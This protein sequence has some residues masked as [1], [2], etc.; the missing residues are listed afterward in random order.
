MGA[1]AVACTAGLQLWQPR[2]LS[3]HT[4]Q[5]TL[6]ALTGA[7][8]AWLVMGFVAERVSART[9]HPAA[10]FAVA[11]LSAVAVAWQQMYDDGSL[12]LWLQLT[13]LWLLPSGLQHLRGSMT[14]AIDWWAL[15]LLYFIAL[16]AAPLIAAWQPNLGDLVPAWS[17]TVLYG[18]L[19]YRASTWSG[20]AA[21]AGK[22][23]AGD[24]Q[25]NTS[26]NTS[27]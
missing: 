1:A 4:L 24:T 23:T 10:S 8:C 2:L 7:A 17:L 11:V 19:G 18:W 21:P 3:H 16:G 13:P 22:G 12:L 15:V 14:G 5:A 20:N 25:R 9:A 26:L 27:G 6:Q